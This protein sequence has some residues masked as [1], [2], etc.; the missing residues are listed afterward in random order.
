MQHKALKRWSSS[1]PRKPRVTERVLF[2]HREHVTLLPLAPFRCFPFAPPLFRSLHFCRMT[3]IFCSTGRRQH[4]KIVL[5]KYIFVCL[6]TW[7][8][9]CDVLVLFYF[10]SLFHSPSLLT[11]FFTSIVSLASCYSSI[12]TS[13]SIPTPPHLLSWLIL[14]L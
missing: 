10:F 6:K 7:Q 8:Q 4:T 3:L 14:L 5:V 9:T 11:D 1:P 2:L 13:P 12:S